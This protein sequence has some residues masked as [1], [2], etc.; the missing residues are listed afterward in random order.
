MFDSWLGEKQH[1]R[2]FASDC[3][4]QDHSA[5]AEEAETDL[6][7]ALEIAGNAEGLAVHT[8]EV[9]ADERIVAEGI[10]ADTAV[11][12]AAAAAVGHD[13]SGVRKAF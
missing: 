3:R 13:C 1:R 5:E 7:G 10:A 2:R 8:A 9:M 12:V 6:G 11:V 4:Q